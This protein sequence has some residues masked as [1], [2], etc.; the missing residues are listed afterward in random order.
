MVQTVL[1][2]F[3]T[4][5]HKDLRNNEFPEN[6]QVISDRFRFKPGSYALPAPLQT[7]KLKRVYGLFPERTSFYF[8]VRVCMCVR[9]HVCVYVYCK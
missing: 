4:S 6:L 8:N 1:A 9:V 7:G 3:C 5:K 2:S